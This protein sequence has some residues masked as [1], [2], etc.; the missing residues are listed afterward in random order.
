MTL[1]QDVLDTLEAITD[2]CSIAAGA[3]AGLVSLGLVGDVAIEEI[4]NGARVD[5]TLFVTEPGC[6]M[7]AIFQVAAKDKIEALPGVEAA[8]VDIDYDYLWSPSEMTPE[9]RKKLEEYRKCQQAHMK[10]FA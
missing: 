2:P 8:N 9:Y 1:K 4:E 10:S 3:P 6:M 7:S 5:V